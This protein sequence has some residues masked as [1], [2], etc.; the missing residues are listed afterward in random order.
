MDGLRIVG[1]EVD[2]IE[3]MSCCRHGERGEG[4]WVCQ[5]ECGCEL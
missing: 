4:Y 1:V 5:P 2:V 3:E